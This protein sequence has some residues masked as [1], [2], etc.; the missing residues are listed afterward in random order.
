MVCKSESFVTIIVD[1]QILSYNVVNL[2]GDIMK[3]R[4]FAFIMVVSLFFTACGSVNSGTDN[5]EINSGS[6]Q[7]RWE[8]VFDTLTTE[9][10][11]KKLLG[12]FTIS[13]N[14]SWDS[15]NPDGLLTPVG[16]HV[17][18]D[19]VERLYN[20][21][22]GKEFQHTNSYTDINNYVEYGAKYFA[23]SED[24]IYNTLADEQY[25]YN[26][27]NETI[28]MHDGLG[29]VVSLK[30]VNVTADQTGRYIID[31]I[32]V[33]GLEHYTYGKLSFVVNDDG[34]FRFLSNEFTDKVYSPEHYSTIYPAIAASKDGKYELYYSDSVNLWGTKVKNVVLY[35][36][37][38]GKRISL[39]FI[40]DDNISGAG[41]FANG[42]IYAMDTSGLDVFRCEMTPQPY[43]TTKTNFAAG[44]FYYG[45]EERYIYAIR[46]DP[47]D[48]DYIV[49]YSQG[50]SVN[51]KANAFEL[52][53]TY[54][55]GLLDKEGNLTHSWDTGVNVV[56]CVNGFEQV[57]LSVTGENT[58][59][60]FVIRGEEELL[61]C[62]VD[63][64]T[65]NCTTIKA[66]TPQGEP[67]LAALLAEKYMPRLYVTLGYN[68]DCA[69]EVPTMIFQGP[70][71]SFYAMDNNTSMPMVK[72]TGDNRGYEKAAKVDTYA[73]VAAKYFGWSY[74]Q[75]A[76]YFRNS[77]G[78]HKE[79][80]TVIH[81]DYGWAAYPQ[82]VKVEKLYDNLYE[83]H[84]NLL[85]LDDRLVS[86]NTL[87]AKLVDDEY[88]QFI[89]NEGNP[90]E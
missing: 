35:E 28:T 30:A 45:P 50:E 12:I 75:M 2:R 84:Y 8:R 17:F 67:E 44:D 86:E 23:V 82:M 38:T 13:H 18:K 90:I 22:T 31:Y 34:S 70:L 39:G 5:S 88:F 68:W 66:Y 26:P 74:E 56:H 52:T 71:E 29:S 81:G 48:F 46:R 11:A 55:V 80:D 87:T 4:F 57:Y 59:E 25:G 15:R 24:V 60:F 58:I 20:A 51:D 53:A 42:D 79:T 40:N 32:A 65:G 14:N 49:V 73:Q 77:S 76:D 85:D 47:V 6:R 83:I 72:L 1:L 61:R 36:K 19:M 41:F 43:F 89:K 33:G 37:D 16:A 69:D 21:D 9:D 54:K 62:G 7:P 63:L 64:T 3:T 27:E 78:Y 10:A